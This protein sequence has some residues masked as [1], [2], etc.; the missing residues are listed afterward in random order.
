MNGYSGIK[1]NG[2]KKPTTLKALFNVKLIKEI[3]VT[4]IDI[5]ILKL[6]RPSLQK[7]FT[8]VCALP[9]NQTVLPQDI[10]V[11]PNFPSRLQ[12]KEKKEPIICETSNFENS[13]NRKPN[14]RDGSRWRG[15]SVWLRS[16]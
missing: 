3:R 15:R 12:A 5:I 2:K 13:E 7:A 11:Q 16:S 1:V 8:S 10:K 4:S 9:Q 14:Q 6:L